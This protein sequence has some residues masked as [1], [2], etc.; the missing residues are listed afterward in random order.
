MKKITKVDLNAE[1]VRGREEGFDAGVLA[2]REQMQRRVV[3]ELDAL[4]VRIKGDALPEIPRPAFFV[5]RA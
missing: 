3:R 2:G 1:Y 5:P 4:L